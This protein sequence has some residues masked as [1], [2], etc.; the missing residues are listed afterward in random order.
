[1]GEIMGSS[2][3][4]KRLKEITKFDGVQLLKTTKTGNETLNVLINKLSLRDIYGSINQ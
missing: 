1:M 2:E 4:L 3:A